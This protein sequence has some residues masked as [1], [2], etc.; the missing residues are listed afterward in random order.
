MIRFIAAIDSLRG[1]ADDKGIPWNLPSDKEYYRNQIKDSIVLMGRKTYESHAAPLSSRVNYVLTSHVE[2]LR[3]GFHAID[4][5]DSFLA[6]KLDIW[7]VG[8]SG[9][10]EAVLPH[11]DELWITQVNGDFGCTKFFPRFEDQFYLYK[12]KRIMRENGIEFQYQIWKNKKYAL[13][14]DLIRV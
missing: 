5:I 11:A 6:Q 14:D 2:P 9:V 4:D 3:A 13:H 10:F 8:G 12:R 1:I 7:V